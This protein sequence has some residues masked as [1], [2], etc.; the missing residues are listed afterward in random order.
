MNAR[1]EQPDFFGQAS[2]PETIP[3][4]CPACGSTDLLTEPAVDEDGMPTGTMLVICE[5]CGRH[6]GELPPPEP[7]PVAEPEPLAEGSLL[8]PPEEAPRRP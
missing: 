5:S 3:S 4:L 2:S 1:M 6:L 7:S 8:P